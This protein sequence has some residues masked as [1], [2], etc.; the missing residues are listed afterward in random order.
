MIAL[1]NKHKTEASKVAEAMKEAF[2]STG[3]R[4]SAFATPP[5]KGLHVS[6]M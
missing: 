2:E 6:E 5:G 3:F 1:I 4:A